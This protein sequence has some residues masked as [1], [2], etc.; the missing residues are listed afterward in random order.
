MPPQDLL[1][2]MPQAQSKHPEAWYDKFT[3]PHRHRE[4]VKGREKKG[5]EKE[6]WLRAREVSSFNSLYIPYCVRRT[7]G[8][9]MLG[10]LVFYGCSLNSYGLAVMNE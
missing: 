8:S 5:E 6:R 2:S 7:I 4:G 9:P 1:I 3:F 10:G